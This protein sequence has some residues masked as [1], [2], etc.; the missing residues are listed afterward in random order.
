MRNNS[1]RTVIFTGSLFIVGILF[2]QYYW[3]RK[4]YDMN[5]MM[6]ENDIGTALYNVA[7]KIS[8][9]NKSP[10]PSSN[11]VSQQKHSYY[12]VDIN[13]EF[14]KQTLDYYLKTEF[15]YKN[16]PLDYFYAIYD[17]NSGTMVLC[18]SSTHAI[19]QQKEEY[20]QEFLAVEGM[21]YYFGIT[22]PSQTKFILEKMLIWI[23]SSIV[24]FI[25]L[26][27][28]AFSLLIILRQKR[29][30]EIQKDFINNMTHEFKTPISTIGISSEV[31]LEKD[32]IRN[33]ERLQYY[34]FIIKEESQRL[35]RQV[36]KVLQYAMIEKKEFRLKTE[37]ISLHQ[38]IGEVVKT[39]EP[40]V[41]EKSGEITTKLEAS[42]DFIRA[43]K[44]HIKNVLFNLLDNAVKYSPEKIK[45][46]VS[47]EFVNGLLKIIIKDIGEGIPHEYQ[48]LIFQKFYRVPMGN[49]HDVKGFG[50]GLDYVK[51]I[52]KIHR[53]KIDLLSEVNK[54]SAFTIT[55]GG[56]SVIT[57]RKQDND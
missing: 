46:S 48:K 37:E 6:L 32:N 42:N 26:V 25:T 50:L 30:S 39:F 15:E 12:V 8:I 27:F 17:C 13:S 53:W 43:D 20:C 54:G 2:F 31:L 9:Y 24:L 14:D 45:I 7:E 44:F 49:I 47:T 41:K 16:L 3:V 55:V 52:I 22:F 33:S 1:I 51:N 23:I 36:E 38:L 35:A 19:A 11:P 4:A 28:F 29:L 57:N 34:A 10:L 56:K 5:K 40:H 21:T 18:E